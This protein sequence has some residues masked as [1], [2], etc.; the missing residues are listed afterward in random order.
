[1]SCGELD[2]YCRDRVGLLHCTQERIGSPD[3]HWFP[4]DYYLQIP[5]G[6]CTECRKHKRNE[7]SIRLI[8]EME[9]HKENTFVTLTLDD[10]YLERFKDD[11]K[12]P[13]KLFV[14]RVRKAIGRRPR[15]FFLPELGPK[16]HRLH[17]HGILFG[18]SKVELPYSLLRGKWQYGICDFGW[19]DHRTAHYVTKYMLKYEQDFK[20]WVLCSNGIGKSYLGTKSVDWHI[21]G[22]E[23]RNYINW[24]GRLYPLSQYYR[25]YLYDEDVKLCMMLNRTQAPP[26]EE[27]ELNGIIYDD[28]VAYSEARLSYYKYTLEHGL[29][30]KLKS[31]KNKQNG[32][33]C[34][35][36]IGPPEASAFE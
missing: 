27:W 36:E 14:D 34:I 11:P 1:M 13:L 25:R 2:A 17:Y 35:S 22:F 3:L 18:T 12:R 4:P 16:T 5:C 29:S 8:I 6:C 10:Q 32:K 31:F 15:Y 26:P 30:F 7:W 20:P 21:N 23:P 19:V 28:F 33:F 9:Q 24:H